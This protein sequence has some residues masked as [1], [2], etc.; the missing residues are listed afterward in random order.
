MCPLKEPYHTPDSTPRTR[1]SQYR[2]E[3]IQESQLLA[4]RMKDLFGSSSKPLV[5][6][7][8]D[9]TYSLDCYPDGMCE[10]EFSY[11]PNRTKNAFL[12]I[13]S[14]SID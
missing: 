5:G 11:N 4:R 10:F 1:E 12:Q 2:Q 14:N 7:L 8:G 6:S 3:I 13:R 9:I